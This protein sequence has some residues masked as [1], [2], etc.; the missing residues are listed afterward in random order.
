MTANKT[1]L[2]EKQLDVMTSLI[3]IITIKNMFDCWKI[4]TRSQLDARIR[5]KHSEPA[6]ILNHYQSLAGK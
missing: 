2:A 4:L 1:K 5:T 6:I 3:I